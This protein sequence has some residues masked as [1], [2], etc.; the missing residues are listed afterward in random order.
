MGGKRHTEEDVNKTD[1]YVNA[2]VVQ[3]AIEL[4]RKKRGEVAEIDEFRSL[5]KVHPVEDAGVY[6]AIIGLR[7][8]FMGLA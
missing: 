1:L 6:E 3:D 7:A 2:R 8:V 4:A 5:T